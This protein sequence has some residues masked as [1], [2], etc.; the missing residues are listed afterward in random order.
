MQYRKCSLALCAALMAVPGAAHEKP[1]E[2]ASHVGKKA[3]KSS[4]LP[5]RKSG[6]WEV[7][8]R[9]GETLLRRQGVGKARAQTVQQCTSAETE[10]VMLLSIL[11]GQENCRDLK[12]P[13]RIKGGGYDIRT[14][15][16][17]H[18]NRVEA[19]MMLVGDLQSSYS[20]TFEVKFAQTPMDNTGRT[21]FEGRWL[22]PCNSG[23][24][25]G[26]MVLPNGVTVNVVDDT[27]RAE[28]H[29]D[30]H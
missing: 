27:K 3:A 20:G 18:D 22:G 10:A 2:K 26:D 5:A 29:G 19:Q 25:A 15:C 24:R 12:A 6:L 16:Y 21:A 28:G 14:V 13:R 4:V 8:L 7:T 1:T 11:P 9:S 23:Q 30:K 17:V